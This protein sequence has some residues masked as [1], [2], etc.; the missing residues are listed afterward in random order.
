MPPGPLPGI[1]NDWPLAIVTIEAW[2][3]PWQ[4]RL[5][6]ET[7]VV[8]RAVVIPKATEAAR[9]DALHQFNFFQQEAVVMFMQCSR[10]VKKYNILV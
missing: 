10:E 6:Q 3:R 2:K 1:Y 5:L 8:M 4:R 7:G 9:K